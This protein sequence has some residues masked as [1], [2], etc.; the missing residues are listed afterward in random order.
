MIY[1]N[2]L[3]TQHIAS[4]NSKW[5]N[6][7]NNQNTQQIILDDDQEEFEITV[8]KDQKTVFYSIFSNKDK[9]IAYFIFFVWSLIFVDFVFWWINK[10]TAKIGLEISLR[11]ERN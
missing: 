7:H 5:H 11:Q 6:S 1:L 4:V 10:T 2:S 9:I 3:N 8:G